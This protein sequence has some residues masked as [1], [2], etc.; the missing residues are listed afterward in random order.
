[1]DSGQ[2][3]MCAGVL[4]DP[5]TIVG[6]RLHVHASP[7]PG[8]GTSSSSVPERRTSNKRLRD[9]RL[10]SRVSR[11][12]LDPETLTSLKS[13]IAEALRTKPQKELQELEPLGARA[14][15]A[16][17]SQEDA[18]GRP[19]TSSSKCLALPSLPRNELASNQSPPFHVM[20]QMESEGP[21]TES[22]APDRVIHARVL[23]QL[24][25]Q[26]LRDIVRQELTIVL[27]DHRSTTTP[28]Q[29]E[30]GRL[31]SSTASVLKKQ[32]QCTTSERM[33]N[34]EY[35][36]ALGYDGQRH[37]PRS[38]AFEPD[39][40]ETAPS[41]L[42]SHVRNEA[43]PSSFVAKSEAE[44]V[45]GQSPGLLRSFT[46]LE[47]SGRKFRAVQTPQHHDYL[48][49]VVDSTLFELAVATI[50]LLYCAFLAHAADEMARNRRDNIK[51]STT[52]PELCFFAAFSLELLVRLARHRA[53]YFSGAYAVVNWV[54]VIVVCSSLLRA[55]GLS[56]FPDMSWARLTRTLTL[57]GASPLLQIVP[58]LKPLRAIIKSLASSTFDL[59]WSLVMLFTA[60]YVF[61]LFFVMRTASYFVSK[62]TSYDDEEASVL[63]LTFGSVGTAMLSLFMAST[64]GNRWSVYYEALGP[65]G[66]V[67]QLV[68]L[69][70]V[71]S[72]NV[73]LLNIVFGLFVHRAIETMA[74]SKEERV[75][76]HADDEVLLQREIR[77]LCTHADW[78]IDDS[79]TRETWQE[80]LAKRSRHVHTMGVCARDLQARKSSYGVVDIENSSLV[81]LKD[82]ASRHDIQSSIAAKMPRL[83]NVTPDNLGRPC[84]SVDDASG[85]RQRL[86]CYAR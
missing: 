4:E 11:T 74:S 82:L 6:Q 14:S 27:A 77:A 31:T 64:G 21:Q 37:K 40:E 86:H 3:A 52:Y 19:R 22:A 51:E 58:A 78:D 72:V 39:C 50:T 79:I 57:A 32:E 48:S 26:E 55:L 18:H 56:P 34:D 73:G 36:D 44:P 61:A 62:G 24:V 53:R 28:V 15:T 7:F 60:L 81:R 33:Q 83:P 47:K 49:R 9:Q 71:A 85:S 54:D 68:F 45:S 80:S 10:S 16:D 66:Y 29:H 1:M 63:T 23:K 35:I 20:L 41:D 30:T 25:G 75:M 8:P 5:G 76:E 59:L 38:V 13:S 12:A 69:C 65:T 84:I 42:G 67:N 43:M 17:V 46:R 70:F 2:H